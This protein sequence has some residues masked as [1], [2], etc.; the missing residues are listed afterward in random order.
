MG[1]KVQKNPFAPTSLIK[2]HYSTEIKGTELP[3]H[4]AATSL[5][6]QI[7]SILNQHISHLFSANKNTNFPVLQYASKKK[8]KKNAR[9]IHQKHNDY[10]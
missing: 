10:P 9:I 2:E 4:L 8:F 6:K 1:A 7:I 3:S 5:I